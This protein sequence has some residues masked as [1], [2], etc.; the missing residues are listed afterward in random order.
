MLLGCSAPPFG[1]GGEVPSWKP[2]TQAEWLDLRGALD[3]ERATTPRSP[4]AANVRVTLRV[5][6]RTVTG[7]GA[8]A[9]YPGVAF[10]MIL[11]GGPGATLLD[12]WVTRA[13]W[14]V[15]IPPVGRILR[16][17]RDAPA[18]LPVAFLR[19][20]FCAPLQG[21]LFAGSRLPGGTTLFVLRDGDAVVELREGPRG[22]EASRRDHGK[23][24]TVRQSTRSW[25][26]AP[27]DAV[28]YEAGDVTVD[29]AVESL[30]EGQPAAEAFMD[31]DAES[32]PRDGAP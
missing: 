13:K 32:G 14:R 22:L 25:L 3:A 15:A 2:L 5:P 21:T 8:V 17:G 20:W 10:R 29:L 9:S 24:Q 26:P 12:V 16:G 28:H 18:D 1:E 4:W 30:A 11:V 6:G 23:T 7:R 31:P 27:G 19:W